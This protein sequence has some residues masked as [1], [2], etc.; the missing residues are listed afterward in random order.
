MLKVNFASRLFGVCVGL[1]L[2]MPQVVSAFHENECVGFN[3]ADIPRYDVQCA[4][5][6]ESAA[7]CTVD[8]KTRNGFEVYLDH[9]AKCHGHGTGVS[10]SPATDLTHAPI[11]YEDLHLTLYHGHD[12]NLGVMPS[13]RG[14]CDVIPKIDELYLYLKARSDGA[15]PLGRPNSN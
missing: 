13:W 4:E 7:E 11:R 8:A 5:G 9:C 2:A 12:E 14:N 3:A 1:C 15:L 10:T 6:A